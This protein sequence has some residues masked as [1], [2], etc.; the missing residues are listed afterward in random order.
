M[1]G[2]Q[3]RRQLMAERD[4]ALRARDYPRYQELTRRIAHLPLAGV[5]PLSPKDIDRYIRVG[6]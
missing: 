6:H 2:T 1:T 4:A 5:R 3:M